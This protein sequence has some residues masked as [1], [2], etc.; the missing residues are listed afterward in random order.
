MR[1]TPQTLTGVVL[2]VRSYRDS[3]VIV[4]ILSPTSGRVSLLARGGRASRKRFVGALDLFVGL[5]AQVAEGPNLW[6]LQAADVLK[7]RV[8]IR[9]ALERIDRASLMVDCARALSPERH[10]A[11]AIFAALDAGL[12]ALHEGELAQAVSVYPRLVAAAGLL[13]DFS[14]CTRCGR[15]GPEIALVG[16]Q[17][18]VLCTACAPGRAPISQAAIA[19]LVGGDCSDEQ[20]AAEVET[21]VADMVEAQIGRPLRSRAAMMAL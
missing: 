13:P 6:T 9:A 10:E 19:V 1:R 16:G 8:G 12:D 17:G 14:V 21:R 20:V 15:H 4:E 2:H 5:R 3:D 11:N 18:E 7:P